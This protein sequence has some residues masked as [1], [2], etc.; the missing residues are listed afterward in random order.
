MKK[1]LILLSIDL[2]RKIPVISL[3]FEKDCGFVSEVKTRKYIN[4]GQSCGFWHFSQ[5]NFRLS[6]VFDELVDFVFMS[7]A[8]LKRLDKEQ[9][10]NTLCGFGKSTKVVHNTS[11]Y[12]KISVPL[13]QKPMMKFISMCQKIHLR[14]QKSTRISY[15]KCK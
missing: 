10:M 2:R 14:F 3:D 11:Y 13:L 4:L 7:Y 12:D 15:L 6:E 8:D 5:N 9:D 1:P